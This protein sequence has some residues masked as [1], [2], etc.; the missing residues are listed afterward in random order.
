MH[1]VLQCT[2]HNAVQC[3]MHNVVLCGTGAG[4][5]HIVW[6]GHS[7]RGGVCSTMHYA[8]SIRQFQISHLLKKLTHGAIHMHLFTICAHPDFAE[9][10]RVA[11]HKGK[12]SSKPSCCYRH[13]EWGRGGGVHNITISK[14]QICS[15]HS[16]LAGPLQVG[17]PAHPDDIFTFCILE[18]FLEGD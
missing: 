13:W 17:Q 12:S 7:L 3:T 6:G 8:S 10:E 14:V 2:V 9:R 4:E 15:C 1:N 16:L 5:M 11:D 18:R